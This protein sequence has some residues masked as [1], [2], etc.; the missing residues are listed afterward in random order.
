M[1]LKLIEILNVECETKSSPFE[2]I[3]NTVLVAVVGL[4]KTEN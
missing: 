3:I 1:E 2:Y 4:L